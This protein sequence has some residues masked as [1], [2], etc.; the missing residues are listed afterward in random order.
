MARL[1]PIKITN[2]NNSDYIIDETVEYLANL[3]TI[4]VRLPSLSV[5]E[6][7]LV[8][9]PIKV[10]TNGERLGAL[11]LAMRFDTTLLAFKGVIAEEKVGNWMSFVNP[12][13]GVVEWGGY[14][15]SNN[16]HLLDNEEQVLTLQFQAL[17][18]KV[19]WNVSPL[20]VTRKF[21]GNS[22]ATDLNITPT[23]GRV[24]NKRIKNPNAIQDDAV[25]VIQVSPNPTTGDITIQFAIPEDGQTMVALYDQNGRKIYTVVEGNMPKGIYTYKANI[26]EFKAGMYVANLNTGDYKAF[27]KIILN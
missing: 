24:E 2:P 23:D 16:E 9:I 14:D 18:P 1:T 19:D 21:A 3:N 17:K 8:N 10:F 27:N 4:E 13:S 11:Q 22:T 12:N 25:A 6:G 15:V 5:D 20:Y 26:S 7:N